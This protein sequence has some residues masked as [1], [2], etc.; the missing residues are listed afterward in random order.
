MRG[1][2]VNGGSESQ[3]NEP[4]Q[5][6]I[7]EGSQ[8]DFPRLERRVDIFYFRPPHDPASRDFSE[9][10]GREFAAV[11]VRCSL[12]H[13]RRKTAGEPNRVQLVGAGEGWSSRSGGGHIH[14]RS[15]ELCQ[16]RGGNAW[17]DEATPQRQTLPLRGL[18]FEFSHPASIFTKFLPLNSR[19]DSSLVTPG[20]IC[21]HKFC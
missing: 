7:V 16:I 10:V 13:A 19:L 18:S 8:R 5:F 15:G 12:P 4:R 6:Q 14:V 3:K 1:A 11:C 2:D 9:F 20:V 17:P 21:C